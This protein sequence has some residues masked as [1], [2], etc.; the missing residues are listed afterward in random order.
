MHQNICGGR[1][2][3]ERPNIHDEVAKKSHRL[4]CRVVEQGKQQTLRA[5]QLTHLSALTASRAS[6]KAIPKAPSP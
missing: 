2:A 5:E 1:D 6:E 3:E 4:A